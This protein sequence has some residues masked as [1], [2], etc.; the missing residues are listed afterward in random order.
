MLTVPNTR[1]AP[2]LGQHWKLLGGMSFDVAKRKRKSSFCSPALSLCL[3]VP[4]PIVSDNSGVFLT[5]KL[6]YK[7]LECVVWH[8]LGNVLKHLWLTIA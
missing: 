6:S 7:L 1:V 4:F 5:S 8:T 3:L 2:S